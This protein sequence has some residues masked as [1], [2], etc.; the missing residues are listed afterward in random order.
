MA[1]KPGQTQVSLK[2][3]AGGAP[4]TMEVVEKEF[5][6]IV[7]ENIDAKM[8][9][10][11]LIETIKKKSKSMIIRKPKKVTMFSHEAPKELPIGKMFSIGKN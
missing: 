9:K 3:V 6:K 2:P 10:K 5:S 1:L 8:T 4:G 11:D 7:E